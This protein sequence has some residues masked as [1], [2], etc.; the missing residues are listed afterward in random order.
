MPEQTSRRGV[1]VTASPFEQPFESPIFRYGVLGLNLK[2]SADALQPG[3]YRRLTNATHSADGE[4]TAR[5]GL[6]ALT[7]VIDD[8]HSVR[9]LNDPEDATWTRVWGI[10]TSI[11]VGQS[12]ALTE[13]ESGFSGDPLSLVPYRPPL[14]DES[15][16]F[17]TDRLKGRKVRPDGLDLPISLAFPPT[18]PVVTVQPAQQTPICAFDSSDG[19]DA[20]A[21]TNNAGFDYSETPQATLIPVT[22][23]GG[24]VSGFTVEFKAQPNAALGNPVFDAAKGY[25]SYWGLPKTLNLNLVGAVAAED[26]D[27]IHLWVKFSHPDLTAEFRLYFVC[28]EIFD[29]SI[30]PGTAFSA[31]NADFY[32]KTWRQN[33]FALFLQ[34]RAAQIDTAEVARVRAVRDQDLRNREI[35]DD[36]TS[37]EIRR[38][39]ID[40][41]RSISLQTGAGREQWL[42]YGVLGLPVRRGDFTRYGSTDGRDWSTVTGII[43]Y[44]QTMDGTGGETAVSLDDCYLTGGS[45]PDSTEPGAQQYDY[46]YTN[47]DPRTGDEGNPCPEQATTA[48]VDAARQAIVVQPVPYGDAAVRQRVY[49]RGGSLIA[50]WYF[51]GENDADGAAFTDDLT[52]SAIAAAGTLELDN[53]AWLTSVD[54][55]G[56]PVYQQPAPIL[57]GPLEDLLFSLG[58]PLRPGDVYYCKPGQPGSWPAA[59]HTEVCPPSEV[60][61]NGGVV[62]NQAFVLSQERGYFLY[63][64]LTGTATS[65]TAVPSGC[66][67]GLAGRWAM[68]IGFGAVWFVARDGFYRTAGGPAERIS[69]DIQPLFEGKTVEGYLPIDFSAPNALRVSVHE[70]EIWFLYKDTS[71]TWRTLIF[72]VL[73][74]FWRAYQWGAATDIQSAYSDEGGEGSLLILGGDTCHQAFTH[75][76]PSDNETAISVTVRSGDLTYGRAREDKLFGDLILHCDRQNT[77]LTVTT[78][79]N[80]G[81]VVNAGA[82]IAD[83]T[84]RQPYILDVFGPKPQKARTISVEVTWSSATDRPVLYQMAPSL[85]PQPDVTITRV[86]QWEDLG[87]PDE[88][89]LT[90]LTLDV[91]TGDGTK[92]FY[93]EYDNADLAGTWATLGPFEVTHDDRH[94]AKFSWPA[95]KAHLVR[96]RPVGDCLPWQLYRADWIFDPEPPRIAGWDINHENPWDIYLTG[97]DL[98]C[99]TFNLVKTVELYFDQTLIHTFNVQTNGRRVFHCTVQ[100]PRRG[101]VLRFVATDANPGLLYAHRW[102]YDKE[103]SEQTNWNQ[104]YVTPGLHDKKLKGVLIECD[105][106]NQVKNVTI[107]IDGAVVET[108]AVQTNGRKL[109]EFSWPQREGRVFRMLPV[110]NNPGR[111]YSHQWIFDSEP[112][113]LSRWETQEITHGMPGWHQILYGEIAYRAPQPI[114]ITL[115]AYNQAGDARPEVYTLPAT[116][117]S[118]G[119]PQ[120]RRAKFNARAN[121]GVQYK[122]VITS[123]EA[124]WLYRDETTVMVSP[125]GAG[126][127]VPVRPFGND[128]LDPSR[129]MGVAALQ[130]ATPG[131]ALE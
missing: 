43:I 9:R 78:R 35:I 109:V 86:T 71:G 121:A 111:L 24:G 80:D 41:A 34:A 107:E 123:S 63:P 104:N 81:Q 87:H 6:T 130:A 126:Q 48:F 65:V 29:A 77:A 110:D 16:M 19:S 27:L 45:G 99:N 74:Q 52:D 1:A 88:V 2:D 118:A 114:T 15:W 117:D 67:K 7:D 58:D 40:P 64:N 50:D 42:E 62:A 76:G 103:P 75:E 14:S 131:G 89:Y 85:I 38:A 30:L 23:D 119:V 105:T 92:Q 22:T 25:Y 54:D 10:G 84:L 102:H 17:L 61:M 32:M 98:E 79:L 128:D 112:L 93:V 69:D 97:L 49:R 26:E 91:D 56:D 113:A 83:G 73:Y 33:D 13:I 96:I 100:P 53:D 101:H 8:V 95:V 125:W 94:K 116:L 3:Q 129:G 5:P 37:W 106:F 115:T 28:S 47:Y 59:N 70:Q 120:K 20:A 12:G 122:W 21:W 57:F 90:G 124:F 31:V 4:L 108:I 72:S 18:A 55:A 36:R 68:A 46:R 82:V 44:F 11:Y 51:C 127:R 60:L 66:Q 39:S